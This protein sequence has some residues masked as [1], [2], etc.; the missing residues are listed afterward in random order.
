MIT[1]NDYSE[2]RN[3]GVRAG[4]S[5]LGHTIT[6]DCR[7]ERNQTEYEWPKICSASWKKKHY[8][9]EKFKKNKELSK[10]A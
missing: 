6:D 10:R 7:S 3:A 9:L 4:F 5:N 1:S 2:Q 8:H